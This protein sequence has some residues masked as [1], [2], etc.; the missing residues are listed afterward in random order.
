MQQ[1]A[2]PSTAGSAVTLQIVYGTQSGNCEWVSGKAQSTALAQGFDVK[3]IDMSEIEP[4][5]LAATGEL[6]VICSTYN[7]GD[8]PDDAED[9]WQALAAPTAPR[10]EGVRYGVLALGDSSYD[11]Y[12]QAGKNI[13]NRLHELGAQRIVDRGD[14][15]AEFQDPALAWLEQAIPMFRAPVPAPATATETPTA[16]TPAAEA[17]AAAKPARPVR[18]PWNR[19]NPYPARIL[20]NRVLSAPGSAKEVRHV[21]V[22]LGD[23][24]ITYEPGDGIGVFAP[25]DPELVEKLLARLGA[26]GNEVITDRKGDYTLREAL[27]DRFEITTASKYLV[28]Y[29]AARSDDPELTHLTATGDHE[30]LDAWLWGRDVLDLLDVDPSLTITP[31]ELIAELRP[32]AHRVYSISSSPQSHD[33]T[34][35]M[36]IATVRHRSANRVRGGAASTHIADRRVVGDTLPVFISPN[37]SFRL[38]AD[39]AKVIMVG[40]GTGVAPFRSFLHERRARGAVGENWLFF[41]DQHRAL[42]H[43]YADDLDDFVGDG[44]LNRLDLAFSRDQDHK[45]YVQDRMR[46]NAGEVFAWL[47][48]GAYLY[49]CGDATRMARD[50]DDALHEIIAGAGGLGADATQDYVDRLRKDKRYLRDVY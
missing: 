8:M 41:G 19:K 26:E 2:S 5:A 50:V 27:R 17:P 9:F 14:C 39:D 35:H 34:V 10:L 25:N 30:A 38:P 15:D 16:K 23:S 33:G 3:V 48:S 32:L 49:V 28:D 42:D 20:T 31:E 43:I 22:D 7:E 47:E 13:D 40:P 18:S 21:V 4:A 29:I 37:K 46:E 12:C 11:G 6:L 1:P 45:V 24:G 44:T 36:T